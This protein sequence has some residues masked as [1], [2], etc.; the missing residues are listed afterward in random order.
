MKLRLKTTFA[1]FGFCSVQLAAIAADA[2]KTETVQFPAGKDTVTGFIAE[3]TA[4]GRHPAIIVIASGD[5]T[6]GL[7]IERKNWQSRVL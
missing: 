3:P 7:R 5:L 1:N 4:A 6:I 2:T